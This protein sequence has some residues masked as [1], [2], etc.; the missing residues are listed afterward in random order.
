MRNHIAV[1]A[2]EQQNQHLDVL[3][4]GH[5]R[6]IGIAYKKKDCILTD[7]SFPRY[8]KRAKKGSTIILME[9]S[10]KHT[11]CQLNWPNKKMAWRLFK[12][13]KNNH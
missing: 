11:A 3:P 1:R 5:A 12:G 9:A 13:R 7:L 2:L 10:T 6:H 8:K 4:Q